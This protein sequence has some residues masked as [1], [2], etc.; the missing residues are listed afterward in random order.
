[1][2]RVLI[3]LL[4]LMPCAAFA[5]DDVAALRAAQDQ[6]AAD[7]VTIAQLQAQAE[8][9]RSGA[10]AGLASAQQQNAQLRQDL[11]QLQQAANSRIKSNLAQDQTVLDQAH[12]RYAFCIAQNQK[13]AGVAEDILHLYQTQGFRSILLK[14]YEPIL[15]LDKVKLEN[16]IQ[17]YDDKIAA[18]QIA[19]PAAGALTP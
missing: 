17:S 11:Q 7:K 19:Q 8:T 16:L 9:A 14:S 4:L 5:Q 1:M 10:A 2:M 3:G 13:L 15:G 6:I 12:S 18:E